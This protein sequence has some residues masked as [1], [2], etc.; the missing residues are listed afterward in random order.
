MIKVTKSQI[1]LLNT[2]SSFDSHLALLQKWS[3]KR[4]RLYIIVCKVILILIR[5]EN[6]VVLI[7][8]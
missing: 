5:K 4:L 8:H 2:E 1:N 6:M 7:S 3:I